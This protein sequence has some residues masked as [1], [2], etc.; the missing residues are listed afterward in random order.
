MSTKLGSGEGGARARAQKAAEQLKPVAAKLKPL[1][2]N[3]KTAARRQ[4]RKTRAWAAPQVE[5]TGKVLQ[6]NV[7]PKVSEM[8]SS[9]AHRIDPANDATRDSRGPGLLSRLAAFFR[10]KAGKAR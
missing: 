4:A 3:T 8:L 9:A 2:D 5:R 6:E 7:A 10:G 1:A